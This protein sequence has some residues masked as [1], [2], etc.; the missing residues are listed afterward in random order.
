M[1]STDTYSIP[2]AKVK[3][4]TGHV[5]EGLYLKG[6]LFYMLV[7]MICPGIQKILFVTIVNSFYV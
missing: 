3:D 2:G 1:P 6:T 5:Y 4:L 7:L